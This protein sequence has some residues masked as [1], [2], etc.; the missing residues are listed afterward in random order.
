M[1]YRDN[2]T[3]AKQAVLK[4]MQELKKGSEVALLT[5]SG[6]I[7]TNL[8]T[9]FFSLEKIL[10]TLK[11]SFSHQ[12]LEPSFNNGLQ[13]MS[14]AVQAQKDI[15]IITDLQ[16]RAVK[17]VV[18]RV[19]LINQEPEYDITIVDIGKEYSRNVGV[20][21]V[22]LNPSFPSPNFPSQPYVKIKNYSNQI[23]KRILSFSLKLSEQESLIHSSEREIVLNPNEEKTVLIDR[24]IAQYG[25]YIAEARLSLDSLA[26]D[27][28]YFFTVTIAEKKRVLLIRDNPQETQY[29][30]KALV[31]SDFLVSQSDA[32]ALYQQNLRQYSVIGL[33]NPAKLT[34]QDFERVAHF[35]STGGGVFIILDKD[36][37]T[38]QWANILN[39]N[40]SG[41]GHAVVI[42]SPD[43]ITIKEV[44]YNNP[45]MEIFRDINLSAA[46]FYACWELNDFPSSLVLAYFSSGKP[47]LMQSDNQ[48]IIITL[49]AFDISK[50]DFIFKATFLPLVHRIFT[51]LSLL[52]I[53]TDYLINDTIKAPLISAQLV[54]I[55]TPNREYLQ[56]P[57][58]ENGQYN[59]K[60]SET[61]EPGFYYIGDNV[62][63]VNINPAEGDLA[64]I[65]QSELKQ[66]NV[67]IVNEV[68][69][70]TSDFTNAS[71]LVAILFLVL[72]LFLLV[73]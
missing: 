31:S 50:T 21:E 38:T 9:D 43:F 12:D 35:V 36:L 34:L 28:Y 19:N 53:K 23:N 5:S 54:K 10:D 71:V 30:E 22:F 44:N 47:F 37:Q 17:S 20:E 6:S 25:K 33:S 11:V 70:K 55:Q 45:I 51:Y 62:F 48:R 66:Y 32:K 56:T 15:F 63:S 58:I 24:E 14:D 69:S 27:D 40:F 16:T 72:E 26:V 68:G 52:S 8:T 1:A 39:L 2:F 29:I 18:E 59:L 3:H 64:R 57:G 73:I 42:N 61:H 41:S 13:V 67:K 65:T 46:R 4:L 60:F 7:K 49:T